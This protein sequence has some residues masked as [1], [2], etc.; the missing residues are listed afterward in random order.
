MTL[1]EVF[2]KI[3]GVEHRL[4]KVYLA[5]SFAYT[6]KELTNERKDMMDKIEEYLQSDEFN[7]KY[8]T[9]ELQVYNPSKL[10]IENAWDY[11]YRDWGD[12]VYQED[13]KQLDNSDLVVFVSYGKENN[14]GSV[15]EVGYACGKNIPVLLVSMNPDSP[16]S[17]MTLHS[18]H[19][20]IDGFEGI[21]KYDFENMPKTKIKRVES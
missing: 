13:K 15:W 2:N 1:K 11:S 4:F 6:D 3:G 18:A 14:A 10:K 17:L 21:K 20:C 7:I 12:L 19:A 5:C 9:I 16:E 8:K